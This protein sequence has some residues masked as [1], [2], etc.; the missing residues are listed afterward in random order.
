MSDRSNTTNDKK[1][2][3]DII[4]IKHAQITE[5]VITKSKCTY[6]H[7]RSMNV[8]NKKI[9]TKPSNLERIGKFRVTIIATDGAMR[10]L[11]QLR[12]NTAESDRTRFS[13]S[14]ASACFEP[15]IPQSPHLSLSLPVSIRGSMR[16]DDQVGS[17]SIQIPTEI[18][19]VVGG[20]FGGKCK[21]LKMDPID[22]LKCRLTSHFLLIP[23]KVHLLSSI[24]K[25]TPKYPDNPAHQTQ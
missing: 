4:N 25:N 16:E 15:P 13:N 1:N 17:V 6:L 5:S 20:N 24:S 11:L 2:E 7:V 8:S 19:V 18:V 23:T 14:S 3:S 22:F 12:Q 10:R 21:I 9:K